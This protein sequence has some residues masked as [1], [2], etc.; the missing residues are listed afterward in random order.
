[1]P[2]TRGWLP[3]E[4]ALSFPASQPLFAQL[5]PQEPLSALLILPPTLNTASVLLD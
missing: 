2:Q 1:M 5:L 3:P 4:Q